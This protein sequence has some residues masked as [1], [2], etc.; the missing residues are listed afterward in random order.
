MN[1]R[2]VVSLLTIV[3]LSIFAFSANSATPDFQ[4]TSP[5]ANA[6]VAGEVIEVSGVGADPSASIELEVLTNAYYVQDG[7]GRVNADGTWTYGPVH[8]AGKGPYNNHTLKATIIKN[9]QRGKS[10]TVAGIVRR[11]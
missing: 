6:V 8:L 2:Y 1:K 7:H 5:R 3:C 4:I 10:T 9:G 11:P